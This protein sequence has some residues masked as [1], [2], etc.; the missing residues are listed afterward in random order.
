[1]LKTI[2]VKLYTD[3]EQHDKLLR[4]MVR[5]NQACNEISRIAFENKEFGQV[6]L[7]KLCYY[8]IRDQFE[9]SAQMTVRA[10]GKVAE[11]YKDKSR[12]HKQ[13]VFRETG[14]VVYDQRL[15]G[16]KG[17]DKVSL[18]TLDGRTLVQL[19][20]CDYYQNSVQ[21]R[22]IAGQADLVLQNNNF[23]LL[24]VVD[25]PLTIQNISL[26]TILVSILVSRT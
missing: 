16:F 4:T 21:G 19:V 20:V 3:S 7:H 18:W 2:K 11:S 12:R 13:H 1:M 26:K 10:V 17:L 8:D 22:R 5:F 25:M 9:L 14:A 23:Y 6:G 15:M 24:V